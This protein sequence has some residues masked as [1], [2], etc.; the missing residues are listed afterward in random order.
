ML[1]MFFSLQIKRDPFRLI[2]FLPVM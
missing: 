2:L 1:P